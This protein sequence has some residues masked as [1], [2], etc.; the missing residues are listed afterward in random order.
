MRLEL[1]QINYVVFVTISEIKEIMGRNSFHHVE[2][3]IVKHCKT[4]AS[5]LWLK[6]FKK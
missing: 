5:V 4:K 3:S 1:M 2:I 6:L